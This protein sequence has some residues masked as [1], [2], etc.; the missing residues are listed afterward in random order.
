M[1]VYEFITNGSLSSHNHTSNEL[2]LPLVL[3]LRVTAESTNVP[4][5]MHL[6][7]SPL[8][9][10]HGIKFVNILLDADLTTMDSNFN[11]SRLALANAAAMATLVQ[12]TLGYLNPEYLLMCQLT[13]KGDMYSFA[14][15]MLELL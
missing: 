3:C 9:L 6:S 10:H 2:P 1:L 4:A 8:I 5:Y 11:T 7:A 14:V 15:V 13:S 12:G